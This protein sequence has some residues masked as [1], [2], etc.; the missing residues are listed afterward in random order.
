MFK[1]II[2]LLL[3]ISF[4]LLGNTSK[5]SKNLKEEITKNNKKNKVS[6]VVF[7]LDNTLINTNARYEIIFN[8]YLKKHP[9]RVIKNYLK[10]KSF[11]N[12]NLNSIL[13]DIDKLKLTDKQKEKLKKYLKKEFNSE[14]TLNSDIINENVIDFITELHKNGAFII[15]MTKRNHKDLVVTINTLNKFKFPIGVNKTTLIMNTPNIKKTLFQWVKMGKI[16]GVF[17][18]DI[19]TL[20]LL[21]PYFKTNKLFYINQNTVKDDKITTIK[22][23]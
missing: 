7:D 22:G 6:F 12:I 13:T 17:N 9:L 8:N 4:S 14:R 23:F 1:F 5:I 20:N 3:A 10:E 21:K 15:Y 19:N 2:I 11:I 16:I 18:S